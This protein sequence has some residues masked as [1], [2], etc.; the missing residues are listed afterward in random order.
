MNTTGSKYHHRRRRAASAATG[1]LVEDSLP[2]L[3]LTIG[4]P[5]FIEILRAV[6][7]S[8]EDADVLL[9]AAYEVKIF[10]S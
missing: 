10:I 9:E 2:V 7:V 3:T 4:G 5:E 6:A 1:V 8:I